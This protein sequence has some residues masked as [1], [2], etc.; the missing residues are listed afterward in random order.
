MLEVFAFLCFV[1]CVFFLL[2]IFL[3]VLRRDLSTPNLILEYIVVAVYLLLNSC[4]TV[5]L[6]SSAPYYKTIV[7]PSNGESSSYEWLASDYILPAVLF[8]ILFLYR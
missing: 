7:L 2:F 6:Y 5:S 3:K 1:G 4:Y 8:Y